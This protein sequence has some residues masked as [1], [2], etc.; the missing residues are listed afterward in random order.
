[1]E[2]SKG[3]E[4]VSH[5]FERLVCRSLAPNPDDL[6]D[7]IKIS[8]PRYVLCG[9]GRDEHYEFEIK[10]T[11]LHETWTVFRRY[12]RFREMHKTLKLKYPELATLEFPPKKLFGNKDER[13]I[14][15]RRSHLEA[16]DWRA[17][18]NIA[19][20]YL[21]NSGRNHLVSADVLPEEKSSSGKC[22][23]MVSSAEPDEHTPSCHVANAD[24]REGLS[25]QD[26]Q[27]QFRRMCWEELKKKKALYYPKRAVEG[28]QV[29]PVRCNGSDRSLSEE[30][31]SQKTPLLEFH[32]LPTGAMEQFNTIRGDVGQKRGKQCY[33]HAG[34]EPALSELVS[35]VTM[36]TSENSP[37]MNL[38]ILS[39]ATSVGILDP[40]PSSQGTVSKD[41]GGMRTMSAQSHFGP[42]T[43]FVREQSNCTEHG[44]RIP[45]LNR[46]QSGCR[47]AFSSIFAS[48]CSA[49]SAHTDCRH[50]QHY[51][52]IIIPKP[53][54]LMALF[55]P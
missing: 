7:P 1:M 40:L 33:L 23:S 46:Q 18:A 13:V 22:F 16:N 25:A 26:S 11:V 24:L 50:P 52:D 21:A 47:L 37:E 54:L 43:R 9:Q 41:L 51:G 44:H 29:H 55:V 2:K 45:A 19:T 8:I 35:P 10:I 12:S 3:E 17:S 4:N 6:K 42:H 38:K 31:W 14:A 48:V 34:S 20:A 39:P 49:S 15:E 36:K 27:R 30:K 32:H 28:L 53:G 5:Y